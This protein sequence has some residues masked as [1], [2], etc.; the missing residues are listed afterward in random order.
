MASIIEEQMSA[1]TPIM[2]DFM[3][4]NL[5][6]SEKILLTN[7][8]LEIDNIINFFQQQFVSADDDDIIIN[9]KLDNLSTTGYENIFK[10]NGYLNIL[11]L[12]DER[13]CNKQLYEQ[14]LNTNVHSGAFLETI[15]RLRD[16]NNDL[17]IDIVLNKAKLIK[18]LENSNSDNNYLVDL[19]N[20]KFIIKKKNNKLCKINVYNS[21][22][23]NYILT[24]YAMKQILSKA[25]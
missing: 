4:K 6:S 11:Y 22:I 18:N 23:N 13:I 14:C 2:S 10:I 8:K 3:S 1:V 7:L 15:E 20:E 17:D 21:N 9:N 12:K 5:S 25:N 24:G 16:Y 19:L